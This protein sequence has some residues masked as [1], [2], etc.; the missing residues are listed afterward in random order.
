MKGKKSLQLRLDVRIIKA[1]EKLQSD[2]LRAA[3]IT[4]IQ[5]KQTYCEAVCV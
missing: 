5:S 3:F 2:W 4:L 1:R